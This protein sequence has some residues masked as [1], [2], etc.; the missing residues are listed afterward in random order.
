[1]SF[2]GPSKFRASP[3]HPI[4]TLVAA[5]MELSKHSADSLMTAMDEFDGGPADPHSGSRI[6]IDF[7]FFNYQWVDRVA[8]QT[9]GDLR[10]PFMDSLR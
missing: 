7:L 8:F 6:F 10:I 4:P 3:A 1:M 9:L 2:F 5:I